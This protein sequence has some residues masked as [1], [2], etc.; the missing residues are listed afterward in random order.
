MRTTQ[1]RILLYMVFS[2]GAKRP[3]FEADHSSLSGG[4][5]MGGAKC[6]KLHLFSPYDFLAWCLVTNFSYHI[7]ANLPSDHVTC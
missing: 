6:L 1:L 5:G 4:G 7:T 3:V 2:Q